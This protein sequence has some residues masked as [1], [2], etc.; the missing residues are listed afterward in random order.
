MKINGV[1][2]VPRPEEERKEA[3]EPDTKQECIMPLFRVSVYG[4]GSTEANSE[5][6]I[7]KKNGLPYYELYEGD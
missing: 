7:I 4:K 2:K 1:I 6:W 5:V 3:A